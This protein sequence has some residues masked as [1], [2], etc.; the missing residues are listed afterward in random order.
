MEDEV[1]PLGLSQL[2][3]RFTCIPS[4]R[5]GAGSLLGVAGVGS[6]HEVREAGFI[7]GSAGLGGGGV[8]CSVGGERRGVL[9]GETSKE[10][11]SINSGDGG[12]QMFASLS[13]RFRFLPL[14]FFTA[15]LPLA[16]TGFGS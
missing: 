9:G 8:G 7:D 11:A 14:G 5:S 1:D 16:A 10:I 4:S 3:S 13:D 6:T 2:S 12:L 15:I